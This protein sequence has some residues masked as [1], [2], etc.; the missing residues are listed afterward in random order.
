VTAPGEVIVF[1]GRDFNGGG[2]EIR[3]G[4]VPLDVEL[5]GAGRKVAHRPAPAGPAHL[6]K[7]L[8]ASIDHPDI[9]TIPPG[10]F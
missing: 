3:V 9:Y 1:A 4:G 8:V 7:S 2:V 5:P 6:R 10:A